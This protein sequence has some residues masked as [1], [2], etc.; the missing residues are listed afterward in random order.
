MNGF[1]VRLCAVVVTCGA[2]CVAQAQAIDP[3]H[4]DKSSAIASSG[5]SVI[6]R[7]PDILRMQVELS[8]KGKTLKEALSKLKTQSATATEQLQ[9][10]K[11]IEAS[12]KSGEPQISTAQTDRQRQMEMMVRQR[13]RAGGRKA[14]KAPEQPPVAVN[15]RL[16]AEWQLKA[17]DAEGLLL[18][19]KALED[20]I[21]AADLAGVKDTEEKSAEEE[22]AAEEADEMMAMNDNGQQAKPGE[23][24]FVYVAKISSE[25]QAKALAAAFAKA[26]SNADQLGTAAGAKLGPLRS[27][28]SQSSANPYANSYNN[29][30][31]RGGGRDFLMQQMLE[32]QSQSEEDSPAEAFGASPSEV[33]LPVRVQVTFSLQQP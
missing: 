13:M 23:P 1:I 5:V 7:Q 12:V 25:E 2:A 31:G 22:E 14:K 17:K 21:K 30:Y 24:Y 19:S 20:A 33:M 27:I 6:K 11:A 32:Q 10:L 8:A 18:E 3:S 28:S 15:S 4:G 9:K 26:R 16:T 29:F